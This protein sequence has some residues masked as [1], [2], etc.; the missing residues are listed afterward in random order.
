[1][2]KKID[3]LFERDEVLH[4]LRDLRPGDIFDLQFSLDPDVRIKAKLVGYLEPHYFIIALPTAVSVGYSD[5]LVEGKGLVVRSIVE[6]DTGACIA[7]P[8]IIESVLNKPHF[9]AFL[10]YPHKIELINLRRAQRLTTHIPAVIT[11]KSAKSG[12]APD[13]DIQPIDGIV[14]DI[15]P[16]G[17]RLKVT[18]TKD[19]PKI[20]LF[21]IN[22][23]IHLVTSD[24]IL[25]IDAEIVGQSKIDKNHVSFGVKFVDPKTHESKANPKLLDIFKRLQVPGYWS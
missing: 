21:E 3:H 23:C 18:H 5:V 17:C 4:H 12:E 2:P 6:E 7:F 20:D 25:N 19:Q 24:E 11:P 9:V 10:K 14:I 16:G 13:Q 15:T 8:S 22:L 1:M